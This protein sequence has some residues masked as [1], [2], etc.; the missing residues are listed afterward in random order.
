M[1]LPWMLIA[2]EESRP[3]P[4]TNLPLSG[5]PRVPAKP[6]PRK[7]APA[8]PATVKTPVENPMFPLPSNPSPESPSLAL[9]PKIE[10]SPT[11]LPKVPGAGRVESKEFRGTLRA[12]PLSH[13]LRYRL[14]VRM[15]GEALPMELHFRLVPTP[16]RTTGNKV[17]KPRLGGWRLEAERGQGPLLIPA[18]ILSRAERLLYISG[19]S[20]QLQAEPWGLIFGKKTCPVWTVQV[21]PLLKA[22]AYLVEIAPNLLA[23]C[24]L[25]ARFDRGDI[26]SLDLQLEAFGWKAGT[27]PPENGTA[28]LSSL[29]RW[30]LQG[31]GS[32]E[33]ERVE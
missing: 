4:L 27:S 22:S 16:A 7:P 23:L 6:S 9:S 8:R 13:G 33:T 21:P 32:G 20:P 15:R 29:Q 10:P 24:D 3:Q 18:W 17:Q 26:A 25:H 19:P 11:P 1:T 31:S 5:T 12:E 28:L 30:A 14:Q 2:Q